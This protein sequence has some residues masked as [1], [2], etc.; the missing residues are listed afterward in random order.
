MVL[1]M[2]IGA[3]VGT[4]ACF[5]MFKARNDRE[6]VFN[7]RENPYPY[8]RRDVERKSFF[9]VSHKVEADMD[10][11]YDLLDILNGKYGDG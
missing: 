9:P 5:L 6:L 2:T 8:L 3:T 4:A 7:S 1:G 11:H 10:E